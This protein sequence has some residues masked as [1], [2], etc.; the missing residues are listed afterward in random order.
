MSGLLYFLSAGATPA[1]VLFLTTTYE[2]IGFF[3]NEH[4]YK[5]IS[6]TTNLVQLMR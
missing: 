3:E 2:Y 4:G 6:S 5:C 1:S